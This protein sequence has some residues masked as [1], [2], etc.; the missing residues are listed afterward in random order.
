[1]TENICAVRGHS[2]K[3]FFFNNVP[4]D[5]YDRCVWKRCLLLQDASKCLGIFQEWY[6]HVKRKKKIHIDIDHQTF[7][8]EVQPSRS[9]KVNP[10]DFYIWGGG[11]KPLIYWA[12]IEREVHQH[13]FET[14]QISRNSP[15]TF[16]IVWHTIIMR[17]CECINSG[18]GYVELLVWTVT[19][20]TINMQQLLNWE[21]LL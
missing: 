10:L 15:G 13:I 1:M 3:L 17:V 19:W 9:P 2:A 16:E 12:E 20:L 4:T 14:F 21:R 7:V 8:F 6:P 5:I 18:G 11:I